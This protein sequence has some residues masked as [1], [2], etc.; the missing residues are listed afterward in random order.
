MQFSLHGLAAMIFLINFF[1]LAN[2][3]LALASVASIVDPNDSC[4]KLTTT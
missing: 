4:I 2:M 3:G 1:I